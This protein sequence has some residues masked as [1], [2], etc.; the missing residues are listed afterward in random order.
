MIETLVS[1]SIELLALGDAVK[2][3]NW[4]RFNMVT[5][6]LMAELESVHKDYLVMFR[7]VYSKLSDESNGDATGL[8]QF[9]IAREVLSAKRVSF[10]NTVE[11]FNASPKTDAFHR[12]MGALNEWVCNFFYFDRESSLST[13]FRQ[14]LLTMAATGSSSQLDPRQREEMATFAANSINRLEASWKDVTREYART[15]LELMP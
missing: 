4:D 11:V 13:S 5:T 15:R 2:R 1:A 8:Q 10:L 14:K 3:R 12:F 7:A 9:S 6:P